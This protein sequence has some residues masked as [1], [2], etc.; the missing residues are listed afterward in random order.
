MT[1]FYIL[2]GF[3]LGAMTVFS[4]VRVTAIRYFIIPLST[5]IEVREVETSVVMPNVKGVLNDPNVQNAVVSIASMVIVMMIAIEAV[6][7]IKL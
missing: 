4:F 2:I 6:V 1:I 3:L 5:H 7:R